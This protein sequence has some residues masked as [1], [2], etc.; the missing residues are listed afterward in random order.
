MWQR[1]AWV[2]VQRAQAGR[3]PHEHRLLASLGPVPCDDG[4][5]MT[6]AAV[7]HHTARIAA[8]LRDDP[9]VGLSGA[10]LWA[11]ALQALRAAEAAEAAVAAPA[12]APAGPPLTG[13][14]LE[15]RIAGREEDRLDAAG[16]THE[17]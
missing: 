4:S 16:R 9:P 13:A 11:N 7:A 3:T 14:E 12:V 17:R 6:Q 10:C 2:R 15:A 5:L 8:L 1:R